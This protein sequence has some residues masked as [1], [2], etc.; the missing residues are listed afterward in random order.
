MTAKVLLIDE[1]PMTLSEVSDFVFGRARFSA[2]ELS[3]EVRVSIRKAQEHL[4]ALMEKNVPIYG[5][6]TGFGD[7]CFRVVPREKSVELQHNLIAYLSCGTGPS[8]PEH[9]TAALMPRLTLSWLC[10]SDER[11]KIVLGVARARTSEVMALTA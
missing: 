7:S 1:K 5:V 10:D 6:T 2:I 3:A 9:C 4:M 11:E 8:M